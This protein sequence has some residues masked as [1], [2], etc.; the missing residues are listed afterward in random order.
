[1]L[2]GVGD[3]FDIIPAVNKKKQINW[4]KLSQ[5]EAEDKH[6]K[7]GHCSALIKVTGDL[8]DLF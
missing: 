6:Q 7:Q 5:M 1:M 8:S 3:L 4:L 2:N